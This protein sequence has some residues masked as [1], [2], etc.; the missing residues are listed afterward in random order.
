[1]AILGRTGGSSIQIEIDW[2]D[3]GPIENGLPLI[4]YR[5]R[6]K[7]EGEQ[8]SREFR[9]RDSGEAATWLVE[10]ISGANDP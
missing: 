9:G 3:Y 1:M 8:I 6:A 2:N 5:I 10:A 7:R 4:H